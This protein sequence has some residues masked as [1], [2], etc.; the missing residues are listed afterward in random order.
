MLTAVRDAVEARP[1]VSLADVASRV[2]A[3]PGAV[4]GML[5]V[6]VR[7]GVIR[8]VPTPC[9]GCTDCDPATIEM[10]QTVETATASLGPWCPTEESLDAPRR[11]GTATG[12]G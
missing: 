10:Y 9:G 8:R 2:G 12:S 1:A 11:T 3:H 4:R 5:D 7:K 6:W